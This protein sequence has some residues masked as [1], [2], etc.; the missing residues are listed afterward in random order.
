M[1]LAVRL[2]RKYDVQIHLGDDLEKD[3]AFRVSLRNEE[4]VGDVLHAL[5]RLFRSVMTGGTGIIYIR[6]Q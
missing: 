2:S 6:K 5:P 3:M 4:T 1:S